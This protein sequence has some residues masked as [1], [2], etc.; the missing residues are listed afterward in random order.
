V[1]LHSLWCDRCYQP[2]LECKCHTGGPVLL[3]SPEVAEQ[4]I[5]ALESSVAALTARVA[6]LERSILTLI[7][8]AR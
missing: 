5:A 3:A 8:P 1:S 7:A 6:E 2:W 4:R